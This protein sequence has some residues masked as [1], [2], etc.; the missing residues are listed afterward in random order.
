MIIHIPKIDFTSTDGIDLGAA[1]NRIFRV[2]A[3][4]QASNR[5]SDCRLSTK[6]FLPEYAAGAYIGNM[7]VIMLDYK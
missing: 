5:R 1:A 4:L 6:T 3:L 7:E 2:E